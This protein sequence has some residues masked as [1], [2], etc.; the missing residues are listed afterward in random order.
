MALGV[1]ACTQDIYDA[2]VSDDKSKTF[3][4]GHSF[5]ANPLAC[6]A[7]L[8]S[9]KLLQKNKQRLQI[10]EIVSTQNE[11]VKILQPFETQNIIKNL[12]QLGTIMAFEVNTNEKDGYLQN[13][14]MEFTNYCLDNGVYLRAL[15]NTIYMM[16]PYC[17]TKKELKKIHDTIINFLEKNYSE[18]FA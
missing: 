7:A 5:T 9:L 13:I 8:A 2:F 1:T 18:G 15:G 17:I 16:P 3:Y 4:H 10:E 6:T 12:R 14:G 11:F